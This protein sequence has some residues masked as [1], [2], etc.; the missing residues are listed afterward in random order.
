MKTYNNKII[1]NRCKKL[2]NIYSHINKTYDILY[3]QQNKIILL[4]NSLYF[5]CFYDITCLEYELNILF[6]YEEK[7]FKNI[8][9]FELYRHSYKNG[10]EVIFE[11]IDRMQNIDYRLVYTLKDGEYFLLKFLNAENSKIM[12]NIDISSK[13]KN[14]ILT[15]KKK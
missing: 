2:C 4:T 14:Y 8:K 9:E 12:V 7:N 3:I 11:A 10:L 15:F 1:L 13:N 6:E 5:W